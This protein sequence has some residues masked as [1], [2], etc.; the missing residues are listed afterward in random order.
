MRNVFF[1]F[2]IP[3]S[4]FGNEMLTDITDTTI[5]HIVSR[6]EGTARDRDESDENNFLP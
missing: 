4:D 5:E 1:V 2:N 6:N 3:I